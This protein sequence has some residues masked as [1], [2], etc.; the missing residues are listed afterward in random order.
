MTKGTP[1]AEPANDIVQHPEEMVGSSATILFVDDNDS[2]LRVLSEVLVRA[3]YKVVQASRAEAA[4]G[5]LAT[6]AIQPD[7]VIS[8]VE[9]LDAKQHNL[10]HYVRRAFPAMP[11]LLISGYDALTAQHRF[12]MPADAPFLQKPFVAAELIERVRALLSGA[13]RTDMSDTS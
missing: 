4:V 7:L 8:D 6:G 2:L 12:G 9:I 5:I 13:D 11:L 3:G 10:V 1:T